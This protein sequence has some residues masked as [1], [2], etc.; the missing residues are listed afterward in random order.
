MK[1]YFAWTS[2]RVQLLS[3][4]I[5]VL[6]GNIDEWDAFSSQDGNIN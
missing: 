2:H 5:R 1:T 4:L 3:K 6:S